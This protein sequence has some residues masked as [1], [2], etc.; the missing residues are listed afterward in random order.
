MP[1]R[2][3][4]ALLIAG[5]AIVALVVAGWRLTWFQ[6]DDAYI[7]FRYVHNLHAGHGPVWN[8]D[9]F[10]PVEGYTCFLWLLLLW[11][12]WEATGVDPASSA[13]W[14]ALAAGFATLAWVG[15]FVWRMR[16]PERLAAHRT[17]L[18][19]VCLVTI[20]ANRTFVTWLS[21][22][23]ETSLFQL[24]FVGW[25][26]TAARTGRNAS[27]RTLWMLALT[28]TFAA[29]TRPEG[30]L[31]L[32]G[33][34]FVVAANVRRER[35]AAP[36]LAALPM[37][38][39]VAHVVW[40]RLYYGDWLPNT[41]HAKTVGWWPEAGWRYLASYVV[42]HGT[43]AWLLVALA[44][45]TGAT[46]RRIRDRLRPSAGMVA[47][48]AAIAVLVGYYTLR[49]GGDHFE[50]RPLA[51]LVPLT[52]VS[53]LAMLATLDARVGIVGATQCL[54]LLAS[55]VGWLHFTVTAGAPPNRFCPV[56]N[57]LPASLRPLLRPYDR[58]QAWL[59]LHAVCM[60]STT[61]RAMAE[62]TFAWLPHRMPAPD[63]WQ[64][65]PCMVRHSVGIAG[66]T[67]P[68]VAILDYH[69]L[70]EWVVARTPARSEQRR[71]IAAGELAAG[72]Q[73]A[74]RDGNGRLD[75]TELQRA[76]IL[77][78]PSYADLPDALSAI[79]AAVV[80]VHDAD[81]DGDLSLPEL[82]GIQET[83]NVTRRM[84]HER[85]PPDG[86]FEQFRANTKVIDGRLVIEPRQPP[87]TADDVRRIEREW[88]QRVAR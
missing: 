21:S 7:V 86:Y 13:N 55:G 57:A 15:A 56:A 58:W 66:W 76:V 18:V 23:L 74:D 65:L 75:P 27:S 22:G 81:G 44:L 88:R 3:S 77:F 34:A 36:L 73:L 5:L 84:A 78:Q 53:L 64:E 10:L 28:A 11:G 82:E 47:A 80:V 62:A 52:S 8:P 12:C 46:S 19:S 42:E 4:A 14:L 32:V 63:A 16:L 41:F 43:G 85:V 30:Y 72:F 83:L 26:L 49:M 29:L 69:G 25:T 37:L 38:A 33:T 17:G 2:Q 39:V 67:L 24:W 1:S 40:R 79:L 59:Q 51:V 50:Y 60:R 54:L 20:A 87:L 68:D 31:C 70:N 71:P 35:R 6:C 61:H 9:P 48:A 45:L